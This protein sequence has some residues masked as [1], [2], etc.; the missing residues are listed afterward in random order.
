MFFLICMPSWSSIQPAC[1][2]VDVNTLNIFVGFSKD[3]PAT[4]IPTWYMADPY[5]R[6]LITAKFPTLHDATFFA[7]REIIFGSQCH[8]MEEGYLDGPL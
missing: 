7:G 8:R 5:G 6:L 2:V 4:A 1:W 3:L